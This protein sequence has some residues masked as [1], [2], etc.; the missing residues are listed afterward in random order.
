MF[1]E[2]LKELFFYNMTKL[3]NQHI[4]LGG[5]GLAIKPSGQIGG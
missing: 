4:R 5:E 1:E 2:K 3:Q